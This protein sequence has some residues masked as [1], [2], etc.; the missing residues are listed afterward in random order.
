M[1]LRVVDEVVALMVLMDKNERMGR[2]KWKLVKRKFLLIV[3]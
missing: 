3:L 2:R 1:R